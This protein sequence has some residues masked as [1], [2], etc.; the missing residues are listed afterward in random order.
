MII[1]QAQHLINN[2]IIV[3]SFDYFKF[4]CSFQQRE[5]YKTNST[6]D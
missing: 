5:E 1:K 2:F 4:D 3:L 6:S